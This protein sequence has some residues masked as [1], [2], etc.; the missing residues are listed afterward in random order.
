[1]KGFASCPGQLQHI[2]PWGWTLLWALLRGEC[3]CSHLD[4]WF[5]VWII[6]DMVLFHILD[7]N[8]LT[9]WDRRQNKVIMAVFGIKMSII[10]G[11]YRTTWLKV[12][13]KPV[14]K[15]QHRTWFNSYTLDI[16]RK[17][18]PIIIFI[19]T[20]NYLMIHLKIVTNSLNVQPA[21]CLQ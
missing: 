16:Y 14:T 21:P 12:I 20:N 19:N 11:G 5:W 10:S 3:V 13:Y 1:M 17:G 18:Q 9:L 8:E 2:Q 15:L 6:E 7:T 4:L